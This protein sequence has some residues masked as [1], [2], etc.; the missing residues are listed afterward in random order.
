[1]T[2]IWEVID[3]KTKVLAYSDNSVFGDTISIR[4]E[5]TET[6]DVGTREAPNQGWFLLFYP[7]DFVGEDDVRVDGSD[8]GYAEGTITIE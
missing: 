5:N 4:A 1:M 6:G 2:E 3:R 7:L 8:G